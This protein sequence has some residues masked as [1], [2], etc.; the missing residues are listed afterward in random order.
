MPSPSRS[1]RALLGLVAVCFASAPAVATESTPHVDDFG[2]YG[3]GTVLVVTSLAFAFGLF[4]VNV[5]VH[6][7]VPWRRVERFVGRDVAV[8][9]GTLHVVALGVVLV[10]DITMAVG[11]YPLPAVLATTAVGYASVA[12]DSRTTV[13]A[14]T[15]AVALFLA[16]AAGFEWP[17]PTDGIFGTDLVRYLGLAAVALVAGCFTHAAGAVV[18]TVR[19]RTA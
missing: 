4:W 16:T 8:A 19:T 1:L 3:P 11:W 6:V 17:L 10:A 9:V 12:S 2:L 15:T 14:V 5:L 13:A 18:A 7:T